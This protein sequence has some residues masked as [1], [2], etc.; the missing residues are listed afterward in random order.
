MNRG[1]DSFGR[2]TIVRA[3][4]TLL[5]TLAATGAP[6]VAQ[7]AMQPQQSS[8]PGWLF[9]PTIG[10]AGTAD[11][12][13]S[14]ASE[15]SDSASD[16]V[17]VFSPSA[18]LGYRGKY[19]TFHVDYRGA[20]HFYQQLSELNGLDQHVNV[21]ARHRASRFL[22]LF[23]NNST[24]RSPST[25]ELELAGLRFRRQGV[26]LED[27]RAG[28]EATL[29]RRTTFSAAYTFQWINFENQQPIDALRDGGHAHGLIASVRQG[30]ASHVAIGGE[31]EARHATV[32]GASPD[33]N[34]EDALFT[35]EIQ[36]A[37]R[38]QLSAGAGYSWLTA[39]EIG[40]TRAA[41]AL[42]ANLNGSGEKFAWN[43]SYR[44]SF[45]PSFGFGGTFQ[46]EELE[47]GVFG[48]LSRR[49]EWSTQIAL[50]NNDPLQEGVPGLVSLWNR[51]SI[52]YIANRWLRIQGFYT[53]AHQDSQR[54]G[55]RVDRARVGVQVI[56]TKRMR[57]R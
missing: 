34:M 38:L 45:L 11:N 36:L 32:E 21:A 4:V 10:M 18:A 20:Y 33:F 27:A 2:R 55:G 12:N 53:F 19:S 14:L 47:G 42:R 1:V 54:A 25:D 3:S 40:V 39:R 26:L 29:S 24:D 5:L 50:R 28:L 48:P 7:R 57:L 15:G 43:I 37:K 51:G 49:F 13:V 23:A 35:T 44:R 46:N 16:Q 8:P 30:V 31:F 6:A 22:T 41:P 56:A 52:A 17:A 9:V